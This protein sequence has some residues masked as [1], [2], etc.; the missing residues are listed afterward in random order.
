MNQSIEMNESNQSDTM[1][2]GYFT[3]NRTPNSIQIH[4]IIDQMIGF[5]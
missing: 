1:S 3:R 4:E 5:S 2:G